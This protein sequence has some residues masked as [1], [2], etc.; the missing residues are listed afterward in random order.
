MVKKEFCILTKG[1]VYQI[2]ITVLNITPKNRTSKYAKQKLKEFKEK[3][4]WIHNYNWSLTLP[5]TNRTSKSNIKK[6]IGDWETNKQTKI[7]KQLDLVDIYK[8][9]HLI[10]TKH[11][12]CSSQV[13]MEHLLWSVKLNLDTFK[14]LE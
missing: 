5:V 12:F 11:V 14:N 10:I 9:P 13:H 1:L 2:E 7:F 6:D 4:M 3:N 8:T